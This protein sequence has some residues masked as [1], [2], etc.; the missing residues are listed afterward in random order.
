M[1]KNKLITIIKNIER[2]AWIYL[3]ILV[4]LNKIVFKLYSEYNIYQTAI[5]GIIIL[6]SCISIILIYKKEKGTKV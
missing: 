1:N 6:F 4:P 3:I 5:P 2:L